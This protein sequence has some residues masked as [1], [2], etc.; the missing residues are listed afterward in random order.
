MSKPIIQKVVCGAAV[1]NGGKVL[2]IRRSLKEETFPGMWEL[3]SGKKENLESPD[4][5]MVREVKEETGLDVTAGSPF[6]V[7]S[8]SVEKEYEIRDTTQINYKVKLADSNPKIVLSTEHEAFAWVTLQ[9][10]SRYDL[11]VETKNVL[12]LV[13]SEHG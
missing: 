9:D 2:V 12:K 8:Y 7:F 4:Q 5:A 6:Q 11:S 3:P 1:M 13:F 10:V